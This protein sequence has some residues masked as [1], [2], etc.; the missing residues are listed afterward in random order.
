MTERIGRPRFLRQYYPRR[1]FFIT[2]SP[3]FIHITAGQTPLGAK[4]R[5]ILDIYV[6]RIEDSSINHKPVNILVITDGRPS[7]QPVGFSAISSTN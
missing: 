1:L 6:P 2:F 5:Q 7:E 3:L 4:L